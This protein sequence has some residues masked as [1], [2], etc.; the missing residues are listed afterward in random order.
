[1]KSWRQALAERIDRLCAADLYAVL[2]TTPSPYW[3]THVM[4]G[5]DAVLIGLE[6]GRRYRRTGWNGQGMFIF[7][8]PGSVFK[9]NREPLLSI[10]GE[11]AEVQYHPHIDMKTAQGYV[12]PWIASHADVLSKD[13]LE[14]AMQSPLDAG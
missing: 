9:V 13:W 14:V 2:D 7:L 3:R 8:V 6:Q 10:L 5:F 4:T 12:V 1:M 11:G